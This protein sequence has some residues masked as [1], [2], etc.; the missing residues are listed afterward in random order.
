[1]TR[2][3]LN[4][5]RVKTTNLSMAVVRFQSSSDLSL[6]IVS[7]SVRENPPKY[8]GDGRVGSSILAF[9]LKENVFGDFPNSLTICH[10]CF[11]D[12]TDV[13]LAAVDGSSVL[14][15]DLARAMLVSFSKGW[16]LVEIL[17]LNLRQKFGQDLVAE[18]WSRYWCWGLGNILEHKFGEAYEAEVKKFY[19]EVWS[20]VWSWF[21]INIGVRTCDMNW[22]QLFGWKY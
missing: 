17:N 22:K 11:G 18:F 8:V 7:Q 9:F 21:W 2:I 4:R 20:R 16:S 10:W 14:V 12:L 15:D 1:M 5:A 13:T 6:I 19:T 3:P